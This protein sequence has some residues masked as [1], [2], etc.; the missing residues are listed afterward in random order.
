MNEPANNAPEAKRR[1]R[2]RLMDDTMFDFTASLPGEPVTPRHVQ[3]LYYRQQALRKLT[4]S[5]NARQYLWLCDGKALM[6]GKAAWKQKAWQQVLLMELGRI[7]DDKLFFELAAKLCE[8]KPR[9]RDGVLMIRQAR[10][11]VVEQH[12]KFQLINEI[13]RLILDFKKRFPKLSKQATRNALS[14]AAYVLFKS[15]GSITK[16]IGWPSLPSWESTNQKVND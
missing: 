14:D 13:V 9:T 2:P 4:H 10:L 7:K 5:A 3:N 15:D 12:S 16:K 11:G 8:Q 6:A 1:G